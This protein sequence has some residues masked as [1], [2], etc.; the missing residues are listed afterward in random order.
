MGGAPPQVKDGKCSMGKGAGGMLEVRAVQAGAE[1][2]GSSSA[3][4]NQRTQF[5]AKQSR[6][7]WEEWKEYVRPADCLM[8]V[9][10][11]EPRSIPGAL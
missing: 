7:S 11:A 10:C 4:D 1:A 3:A 2:A 5:V 9:R 6:A 8:R